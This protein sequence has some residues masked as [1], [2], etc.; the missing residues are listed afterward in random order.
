LNL[1]LFQLYASVN[2]LDLARDRLAVVK[3]L[4]GPN[5][6]T[7]ETRITFAQDLAQLDE[8]IEDIKKKKDELSI[9]QQL[10][11]V[12]LASFAFSQGAPGLAIRE[13]E[14][15]ERTGANP[16]Q[17]K[18]MLLDLYCDTGQPEKAVEILSAGTVGD[19][20]F[21]TEPG[22]SEWRQGRTYFLWGN[23]DYTSNLWEKYAIVK[24]RQERLT[25]VLMGGQSFIKGDVQPSTAALLEIP[26]KIGLQAAWEFDAGL[27][28]LEGGNPIVAAEHFTK[29][30]TL[31]PN[32]NVRPV[33]AYYLEKLGQPVPPLPA[34]AKAKDA[35]KDKGKEKEKKE[36]APPPK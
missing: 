11:A 1:E 9:E 20:T 15:A 32:L 26:E 6:F 7:Q 14:E 19:P 2:Y 35:E 16:V 25:R 21:G 10:S 33:I 17:V 23:Y 5:D 3:E 24:L 22:M 8:K 27:C 29:A 36:T 28:R 34:D 30:L 4:I 31:V 18:P 12:Q 13:L